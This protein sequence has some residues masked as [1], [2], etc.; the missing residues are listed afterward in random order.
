LGRRGE[1]L[2]AWI[3]SNLLEYSFSGASF[4]AA[5]SLRVFLEGCM[6]NSRDPQPETPLS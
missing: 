3:Y 5:G 4:V 1:V 6:S 2:I